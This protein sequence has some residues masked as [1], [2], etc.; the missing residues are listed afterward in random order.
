MIEE[1]TIFRNLQTN[2]LLTRKTIFK[3]TVAVMKPN[4]HFELDLRREAARLLALPPRAMGTIGSSIK[5]L[6]YTFALKTKLR[7]TQS[8]CI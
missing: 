7:L 5:M 3:L 1:N 4:R 8:R 6:S 2:Q